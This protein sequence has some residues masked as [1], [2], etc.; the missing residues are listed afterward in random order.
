MRNLREYFQSCMSVCL[1]VQEEGSPSDRSYG[2]ACLNLFTWRPPP[3]PNGKRAVDLQLRG[4][5]VILLICSDYRLL[6]QALCRTLTTHT[7]THTHNICVEIQMRITVCFESATHLFDS[8]GTNVCILLIIC[9]VSCV[10]LLQSLFFRTLASVR[11]QTY[12][13]VMRACYMNVLWWI[14]IVW[15]SKI[16]LKTPTKCSSVFF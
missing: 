13:F 5:L 4:I 15:N 8:E 10:S 3:L 6:L 2:M 11:K 7:P 9:S 16:H 12:R 14:T 1:S